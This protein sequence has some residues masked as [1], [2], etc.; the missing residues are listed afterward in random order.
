MSDHASEALAESFLLGICRVLSIGAQ[1]SG[2]CS[3]YC[4][5]ADHFANTTE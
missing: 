5:L 3:T 1:V 2:A 4:Q